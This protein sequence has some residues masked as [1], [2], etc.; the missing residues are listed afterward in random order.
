VPV[1]HVRHPINTRWD[2]LKLH[3]SN[4]PK[5]GLNLTNEKTWPAVAVRQ[6]NRPHVIG[7]S[8]AS[9]RPMMDGCDTTPPHRTYSTTHRRHLTADQSASPSRFSLDQ[10]L[11]ARRLSACVGAR[12]VRPSV[13]VGRTGCHL[14]RRRPPMTDV[15]SRRRRSQARTSTPPA[16]R[17]RVLH[18]FQFF[19]FKFLTFLSY[20]TF[21]RMTFNFFYIYLSNFFKFLILICN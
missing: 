5:Q 20:L 21:L 18:R 7:T 13:R 3:R 12:P 1:Y 8:K 2:T 11:S 4:H 6:S 14:T 9:P 17:S 10:L 15:A 19:F 16:C